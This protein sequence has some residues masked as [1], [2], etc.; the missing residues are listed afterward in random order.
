[1]PSSAQSPSGR[2]AEERHEGDRPERLALDPLLTSCKTHKLLLAFRPDRDD[3]SSADLELLEQ[4]LRHR[5]RCGGY[6]HAIEGRVGFPTQGAIT[7][8]ETDIANPELLEPLARACQERLD[9]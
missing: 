3:Q 9:A 8:P 7:V 4:V 2:A 6:Q 5:E 1:M